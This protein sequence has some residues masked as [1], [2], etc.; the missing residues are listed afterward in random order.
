MFDEI[1]KAS[2]LM[3]GSVVVTFLVLIIL[4]AFIMNR[5]MDRLFGMSKEWMTD[6]KVMHAQGIERLDKVAASY[7]HVAR[8]LSSVRNDVT[9]VHAKI[10]H[11]ADDLRRVNLEKKT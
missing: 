4:F 11:L 3:A 2:P 7:E 1:I 8:E 10:D 6:L 9:A 5:F